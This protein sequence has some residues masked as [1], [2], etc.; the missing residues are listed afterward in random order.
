MG[1]KT[2]QL[3]ARIKELEGRIGQLDGKKVRKPR[4]TKVYT[5]DNIPYCR[6]LGGKKVLKDGY[7]DNI[8]VYFGKVYDTAKLTRKDELHYMQSVRNK[9]IETFGV[10]NTNFDDTIKTVE[11]DM[12]HLRKRRK[13]DA[14][15]PNEPV[16]S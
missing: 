10:F 13:K 9:M 16:K 3:K 8:S 2:V 11:V 7:Y 5:T 4:K 14:V 6:G 15:L 12:S 1:I